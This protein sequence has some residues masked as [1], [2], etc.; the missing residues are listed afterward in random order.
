M[1]QRGFTLLE[2]IIA[3]T[4]LA[5]IVGIMTGALSM[6][7]KTM[8]KGEK[9]VDALERKR[10]VL[11]LI[12]SQIQS[13]FSSEYTEQAEKKSRFAGEKDS[14]TFASNYS[15]WRG[16]SGNSLVRYYI[17]RT[18]QGR[19]VLHVEERI[20]GTNAGNEAGLTKDYESITFQYYLKNSLEEGKW[21]DQWPQDEKSMP[22]K[23][24]ISFADGVNKKIVTA[25]VLIA[26][27]LVNAASIAQ[28]VT[29]K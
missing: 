2:L 16:T 21:V 12:E 19:S 8:E 3:I 13:A 18:D 26:T 17:K 4:M 10:I 7:Y 11:P 9:K 1:N 27:D 20:L 15:L 5:V 25:N 22:R 29:A 14:L 28:P 23:I 24:R 6:A